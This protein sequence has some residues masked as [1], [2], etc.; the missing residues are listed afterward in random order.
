MAAA[1]SPPVSDP[2]EEIVLP[3]ECDPAD[4]VLGDVVVSFEATVGDEAR[5]GITPLDRIAEGLR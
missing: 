2:G 5:E 4:G 3:A 1:R